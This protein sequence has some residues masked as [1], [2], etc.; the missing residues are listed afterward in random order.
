[1]IARY[2]IVW[3]VGLFVDVGISA[4]G[5][6]I[7]DETVVSNDVHGQGGVGKTSLR[8]ARDKHALTALL[9]Q[10]VGDRSCSTART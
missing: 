4:Y 6:A 1:M 5:C 9:L 3:D 10:Y 2:S 7:Y 8:I